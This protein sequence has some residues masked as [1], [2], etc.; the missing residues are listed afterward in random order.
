MSGKVRSKQRVESFLNE[1]EQETAS[2]TDE[3]FARLERM[4]R[5]SRGRPAAHVVVAPIDTAQ[6]CNPRSRYSEIPFNVHVC[7]E[8][9]TEGGMDPEP[10]ELE[11]S[12]AGTD[13]L[14]SPS[15]GTDQLESPSAG[16][17]QLESP[18][19]GT[20]FETRKQQCLPN[21]E[22]G[23]TTVDG[24]LLTGVSSNLG[25]NVFPWKN[26]VSECKPIAKPQHLCHQ[27]PFS[28]RCVANLE[29]ASQLAKKQAVPSRW[30]RREPSL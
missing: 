17:D 23:R 22:M 24:C 12:S 16:T 13:Q 28:C 4:I 30:E 27:K 15:A 26:S 1:L 7:I 11:K 20:S 8:E 21:W 29:A 3:E 18:S 6:P 10:G 25:G 9:K 19:A 14:E 2:V 5:E